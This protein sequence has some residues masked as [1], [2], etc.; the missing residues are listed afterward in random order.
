MALVWNVVG[1]RFD[2][3]N[4]DFHVSPGFDLP[5]LTS[6]LE[7]SVF[8]VW[9]RWDAVQYLDLAV[10][11][12]RADLPGATVFNVLTPLLFRAADSALPGGVD[13]AAMVV[14]T[15]AFA[16]ALTLLYCVS[17]VCY[18]DAG[19]GRWAV[20]ALA[21]MP[22]SFFFA[23]PM[24]ESIHL[25]FVLAFF[26]CAARNRWFVA[27]LCGL[28]ATLARSQGIV[29]TGVGALLLIEQHGWVQGR[30]WGDW[31]SWVIRRGWALAIIPCGAL[32]F[33]AYRTSLGLPPIDELHRQ[34]SYV[35]VTHPLDG[36][37]INARWIATQPAQAILN[38]D[39]WAFVVLL[40]LI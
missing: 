22:T 19:L 16:A 17:E 39:S 34:Y 25:A 2:G 4:A 18:R 15:V 3:A 31:L 38:A 32:I 1:A 10:N 8:G 37:I 29:L 23:A 11:G 21:L 40:T 33:L 14:E 5:A 27:A 35:F 24:S 13:W 6:P 20:A 12:Y 36:L 30:R 9:R 26:V 28:L 7:Q